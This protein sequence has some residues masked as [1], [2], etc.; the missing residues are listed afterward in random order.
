MAT[1]RL[2]RYDDTSEDRSVRPH[3]TVVSGHEEIVTEIS[4]TDSNLRE[5]PNQLR[6]SQRDFKLF[7]VALDSDEEPNDK[8]KALFQDNG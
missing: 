7:L 6:L 1:A 5:L 3:L 2:E 4:S 8:L